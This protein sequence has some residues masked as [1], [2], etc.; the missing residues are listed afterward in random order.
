V[1][2][3]TTLYGAMALQSELNGRMLE[4]I[5]ELAGSAMITLPSS[6]ADFDNPDMARDIE[7]YMRSARST[8]ARRLKLMRLVWISSLGVRRSPPAIR[9][10]LRRA[11]FL[12]KQN[13]NR[14]YDYR[15][16]GP[17][18]GRTRSA[19]PEGS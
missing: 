6:W 10:V 2:F 15:A 16:R 13:V 19:P 9:E 3:G 14:F 17:G 4:I 12:V 5:R 1:A 11:S 8:P 7:R 18:R